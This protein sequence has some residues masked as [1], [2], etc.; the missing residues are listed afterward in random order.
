MLMLTEAKPEIKGKIIT[1]RVFVGAIWERE[2]S[3]ELRCLAFFF[4]P[5]FGSCSAVTQ[6]GR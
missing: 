5:V 4:T 3:S 1:V 2:G 6:R